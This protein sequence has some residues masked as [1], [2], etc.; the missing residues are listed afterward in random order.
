SSVLAVA[1]TN[2]IGNAIKYTQEGEVHIRVGDGK[3][4]VSDTGRG[5]GD[6]DVQRLFQRGVRGAGVTGSGAGLGLAIVVRLCDLYGWQVSLAPR[7]DTHGTI[8]ILDFV[9]PPA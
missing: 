3:V 5:I 7:K 8:A 9:L 4:V 2:L 1:L 6:E